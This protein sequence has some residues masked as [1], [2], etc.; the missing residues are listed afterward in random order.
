[1]THPSNLL[2]VIRKFRGKVYVE[3]YRRLMHVRKGENH[4]ITYVYMYVLD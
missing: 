1:M 3:I 4:D 2:E